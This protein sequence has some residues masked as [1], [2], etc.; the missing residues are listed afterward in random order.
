MKKLLIIKVGGRVVE[1]AN[2]LESFLNDFSSLP[3]PKILVHG[4]G[5]SATAMAE[6]LGVE[7]KM[8]E[9]RRITD[10]PMLDIV[11]MVYAGLVNKNVI[12]G[13]QAHNQ[14]ALGLTGAD[15]NIIKS[16]KRTNSIIDYGYVGDIE[17]VDAKALASLL[18]KGVVPVIAP[19]THNGKG[20]LLNTNADTIA[21]AL[22]VALAEFYDITLNFCFEL[23]GV[24]ADI[25][26][27]NSLI[28]IITPEDYQKLKTDGIIDGGMIPKLDNSFDALKKGVS[29]IR[30]TNADALGSKNP[31]GTILKL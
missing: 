14:N 29:R 18:G 1:E 11:T 16:K 15:L 2:K 28:S 5:R 25:N 19:I 31:R 20:T 10:E 17:Q 6:K 8:V 3:S 26:D 7:T 12:A 23:P 30:I 13:L 24:L 4:G 22:A 9:G 21:S 27:P